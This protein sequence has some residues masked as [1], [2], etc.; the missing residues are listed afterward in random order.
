MEARRSWRSGL[1]AGRLAP[2]SV[3]TCIAGSIDVV[4][5]LTFGGVSNT[6]LMWMLGIPVL[7]PIGGA[8]DDA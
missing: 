8:R 7:G 3:L 6:W 1:C 4:H 5:H 2:S